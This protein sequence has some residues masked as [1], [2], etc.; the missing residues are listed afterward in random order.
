MVGRTSE[1][2]RDN[3]PMFA[4]NN[5]ESK[6]QFLRSVPS[7]KKIVATYIARNLS[8]F[9]NIDI[10]AIKKRYGKNHTIT[11]RIINNEPLSL[12]CRIF[13]RRVEKILPNGRKVTKYMQRVPKTLHNPI[14]K[15]EILIPKELLSYIEIY[16]HRCRVCSRYN[17][18]GDIYDIVT[19]STCVDNLAIC[20]P[21]MKKIMWSNEISV[22]KASRDY[23]H[24][25]DTIYLSVDP[26]N[27]AVSMLNAAVNRCSSKRR[28]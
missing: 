18:F 23:Y 13:S 2:A 21:C 1:K 11:E 14:T 28:L 24:A 5:P 6:H 8:V 20:D 17:T 16:G 26:D 25:K 4:E 12:D 9:C 3:A 7:L 19:I 22:R 27:D 10:N 15:E